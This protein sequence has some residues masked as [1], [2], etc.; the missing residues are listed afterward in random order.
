MNGPGLFSTPARHKGATER[1]AE[2][3]IHRWRADGHTVDELTSSNLR[4]AAADVDGALADHRN[5]DA[6]LFAVT[7]ARALLH[8]LYRYASPAGVEP[9][10][11]DLDELSV[12]VELDD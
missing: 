9:D 7:R 1:A 11:D 12:V 8:E 5:G 3:V 2:R 10:D 4:G 6:G